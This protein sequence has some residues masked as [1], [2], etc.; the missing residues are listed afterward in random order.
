MNRI[1]LK[2][3][4]TISDLSNKLNDYY[5]GSE[6]I[7]LVSTDYLYIGQSGAFNHLYFE[8]DGSNTSSTVISLQ[9]WDGKQ[10]QN[11]VEVNDETNG[12]KNSGFISFVPDRNKGWVND[13]TLYTDG[14]ELV[15]GLSAITVYD[16][17]WIRLKVSVNLLSTTSVSW[18]GNIFSDDNDI[19]SECPELMRPLYM[20]T[21]ETGKTDWK[22]QHIVAA[23]LMINDLISD[24]VVDLQGQILDRFAMRKIAVMKCIEIIY[25]GL[26]DDYKDNTQRARNEYMSRKKRG[27]FNVD[28]N[29]DGI[30]NDDELSVRQG[31]MTR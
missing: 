5:S 17:N 1:F 16:K 15:T 2:T 31:I 6:K 26:G 30:L 7:P 9:Y 27:I 25:N 21:W 3:L 24:D 18:I 22:E 4:S 28:K 13:D 8:V 12:F 14:K 11:A 20:S 10:F 29:Q 19:L 23:E